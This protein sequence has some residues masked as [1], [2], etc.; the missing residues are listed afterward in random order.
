MTCDTRTAKL[1][2]PTSDRACAP[3]PTF[4]QHPG[5]CRGKR[6][7]PE[8]RMAR[9]NARDQTAPRGLSLIHI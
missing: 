6:Q 3:R 2:P 9:N 4:H 1:G 7:R 8:P 5:G